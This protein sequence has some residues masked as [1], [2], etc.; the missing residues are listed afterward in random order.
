MAFASFSHQSIKL[1]GKGLAT[2]NIHGQTYTRVGPLFPGVQESPSYAQLYIIDSQM[3]NDTRTSNKYNTKCDRK[4]MDVLDKTMRETNPLC[5]AYQMMKNMV[6]N[7]YS[8]AQSAGRSPASVR[9]YLGDNRGRD[10]RRYNAPS[11]P[12]QVA[13]VFTGPDGAPP[14]NRYIC[15]Y[16]KSKK[17]DMIKYGCPSQDP[18][19]YPILFP[20]AEPGYT[21]DLYCTSPGSQESSFN[22]DNDRSAND[23][24]NEGNEE[25]GPAEGEVPLSAT[26]TGPHAR[27]IKKVTPLQFYA[28]KLHIRVGD[29]DE[30]F[31]PIFHSK[32]L[33]A[34]YICDAYVKVETDR[35]NHHRNNQ[36]KLRAELYQGLHDYIRS[37][38]KRL[39]LRAGKPVVT[40]HIPW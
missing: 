25:I 7:E 27:R 1:P 3:A 19:V 9:M 31:N 20:H 28:Y 37:E 36:L 16:D 24:S 40:F 38:A 32:K 23:S 26:N 22:T 33:L 4:V 14:D 10:I 2:F 13:I 35:L 6:T 30:H 11:A 34:Q 29:D 17:L 18:M 5:R 12:E 39:G 21:P 8:N 15:V